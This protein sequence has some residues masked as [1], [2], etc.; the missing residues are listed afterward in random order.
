MAI[1]LQYNG[2]GFLMGIPARNL[3]EEEIKK[4]EYDEQVL[5][6]SGLYRVVESSED[7]FEEDQPE[8]VQ[9]DK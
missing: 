9:E 4:N 6:E 1:R 2:K 7:T 3:T 8:I 5:V